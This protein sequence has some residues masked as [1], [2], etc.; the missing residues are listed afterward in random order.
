LS[1]IRP[2]KIGFNPVNPV[3]KIDLD[4]DLR[5]ARKQCN[6]CNPCHAK[7]FIGLPGVTGPKIIKCEVQ[8]SRGLH[9]CPF[10]IPEQFGE[11]LIRHDINTLVGLSHPFFKTND[12]QPFYLRKIFFEIDKSPDIPG[13]DF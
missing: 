12:D 11:F 3:R 10:S 8:C 7:G 5:E 13:G 9:R 2:F 4:L 1:G 6:P